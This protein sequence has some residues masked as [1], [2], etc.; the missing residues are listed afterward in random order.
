MRI[1]G[2]TGGPAVLAPSAKARMCPSAL[3]SA[4]STLRPRICH[5]RATAMAAVILP[6]SLAS[7]MKVRPFPSWLRS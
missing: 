7:S 2:G 4:R 5:W 1:T 3:A 6:S